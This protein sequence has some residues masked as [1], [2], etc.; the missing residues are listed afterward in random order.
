[1]GLPMVRRARTAGVDVHVYDRDMAAVA[2]AVKLGAKACNSA[3]ALADTV[4]CVFVSLP[5]P[6]ISEAVVTG[7][8]GL[9]EG[10][11]WKHHVDL[12]TT[13]PVMAKKLADA[14]ATK[15]V[16]T[17]DAPVSGGPLGVNNGTLAIMASGPADTLAIARPFLETFAKKIVHVGPEVGQGQVV[18]LANNILA[19][20]NLVA[21][22]EVLA[23][24]QKA[25]VDGE[26]LLDVINASSGRSWVS[27]VAYPKYVLTRTWDQG[28]RIELMH[29]DVTLSMQAAEANGTPMWVGAT[30]RQFYQYLMTQ[31]LGPQDVST[32]AAHIGTWAGLDMR[33]NK[34]GV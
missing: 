5:T 23:M 26:T 33:A 9:I 15:G 21:V 17:L 28:F 32:I 8:G 18:K 10:R 7:P 3:A 20:A 13:G 16:A 2:E 4:A 34:P 30:V 22:G 31:G 6:A 1:M 27:E 24:A 29:K 14:L 25:G 11:A 12:S 19:A